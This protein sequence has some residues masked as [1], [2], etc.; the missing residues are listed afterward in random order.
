MSM[1]HSMDNKKMMNSTKEMNHSNNMKEHVMEM[2]SSMHMSDVKP[3]WVIHH[4]NKKTLYVAGNGSN[5]IIEIDSE[6]GKFL[7]E[8]KL[9]RA[10]TMLRFPQMESI[11]L[12]P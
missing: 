8:L 3:T 12:P 9:R 5:E 10:H 2:K 1:N 7:K 4:P 6:N 11:L